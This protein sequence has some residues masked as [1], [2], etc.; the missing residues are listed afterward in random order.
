M[1]RRNFI[2]NSAISAG[3]ALS[4]PSYSNVLGSNEQI[5]V[6]IIGLGS[7]VK[8]GG[9]G[10]G[11]MKHY[12]QIPGVNVAAICDCDEGILREE[13]QKL[14]NAG[15][16]VKTYKDFRD[17][18][19]DKDIDAV[20]VTTPNHS[21]ALITIM[22]CQAGK[23]V[24]CQKPASHN[25]F[26]GRKMVEA[27]RKYKRIVQVPHNPREPNGCKEAFEW[28]RAGNLGKIKYV[29][30]I[31]YKPRRTIEKVSA[32][33]PV[34]KTIDYNLWAGP[35]PMSPINRKYFHYDWHW[36]WETGNGDLGNMGIHYMDGCRMA[37]D[38]KKL[39]RNVMSLGGRFGYEDDGQTP[40]TQIIYFDYEEA[41]VIF[42][43]RGLPAYASFRKRNWQSANRI[44]MDTH[45][46]VKLGVIVY[47]EDGF[48]ANNIAYNHNGKEIKTFHS[49]FEGT[50]GN[51]IQAIRENDPGVLIADIEDGHLSS[52]LVHMGNTSYQMG[53]KSRSE[54]IYEKIE[55]ISCLNESFDRF[56]N[57]LFANRIDWN[58]E[59][60]I[61]GPMLSFDSNNEKYVGEFSEEANGY[62]SRNYRKPFVVREIV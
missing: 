7:N 17:V 22:A 53:K 1:K 37:L 48:I 24:Y 36:M 16:K 9:K 46:G 49:T 60:I 39:P 54:E 57:H 28:A 23:H 58:N 40:N 29:H 38:T 59:D 41:P 52:A 18:L 15:K 20:H 25:I 44:S 47:C 31:N 8:I 62:L 12:M 55:G 51:Y 4:L 50:M 33:I 30:G 21:H 6:A 35:A 5:N 2:K 56:R 45:M 13:E 27:A 32:P 11:D 14:K 26:E 61:L 34:P 42:E 19:D 43:V 3:L 10:K